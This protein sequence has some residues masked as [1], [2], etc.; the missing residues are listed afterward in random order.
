MMGETSSVTKLYLAQFAG[1]AGCIPGDMFSNG[2][3]AA[4]ILVGA[5]ILLGL[6]LDVL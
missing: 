6:V 1:N 5:L 2:Y 4:L 3:L